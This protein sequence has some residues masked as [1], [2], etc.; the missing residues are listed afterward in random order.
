MSS[1]EPRAIADWQ[2]GRLEDG[3][4][5]W[6][7]RI[8]KATAR[9]MIVREHYSHSWNTPFGTHCFGVFDGEG[10]AG[11]LV[12]GNLMNPGSYASLADLP[13]DAIVELN[14]MW[15]DDRLGPN[16]E[17]AALARSMRWLKHETPV[18][19]VQTFADGRLGCGTV[20]KAANFGYYGHEETLFFRERATGQTLHG[21]PF[22]NTASPKGML[23]RNHL[24]ARGELDAFYV[25]TYRY[26]YPLTKYAR[27]RIIL[28]ERPYPQYE[29][30]ERRAPDYLAPV[31][32]MARALTIAETCGYDDMAADMRA[33]LGVNYLPDSVAAALV[34][35]RQNE[36][37]AAILADAD[38]Q[39]SLFGGVA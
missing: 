22:S 10:L 19:L 29:R 38:T 4:E 24:L 35:A 28:T 36:W 7:D 33:Y 8:D 3:T 12:F 14:R 21:T 15:V 6:V 30:G 27:R 26:L 32:Q 9:D 16:T 17:S 5:F 18:Q 34:E 11:A 2:R 13:P 23:S 20:Y 31:S 39:P 25:K 1:Y 37:V